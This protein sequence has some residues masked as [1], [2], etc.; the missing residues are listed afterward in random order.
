LVLGHS[1]V[2]LVWSLVI[3]KMNTPLLSFLGDDFTGSTDA[4]E[5]LS[6]AGLHTILFTNPPTRA[7]LDRHP[8]LQAFGIAS[9]TRA[10]NPHEMESTLPPIFAALKDSGAPIIHYKTCSTF[11]SSPKI[12]SIGKVIDIAMNQFNAKVIPTLVG[13]PSLGRHCV[14]GNLF[15]QSG[16]D[17]EPFRLD[18]HPSMSRH[19][20]TPMDEADL[21]LHLA[22]QTQKKIGLLDILALESSSPEKIFDHLV[23]TNHEIILIDMLYERQL[24]LAGALLDHLKDR[25]KPLFIVGSSG[26]E[27]ALAAHWNHPSKTFAPLTN[28]GPLIAV[29]GSCSP[30][31]AAQIQHAI[32]NGFDEIEINPLQIDEPATA[33]KASALIQQGKSV[34]LHTGMGNPAKRVSDLASQSI[35]PALGAILHR[36]LELS[37]LRRILIAGGDTSGQIA[38]ALSIE[39][40]EMIAPLTRGSPLCKIS[41][42]NS[43]A[44]NLEITFKGGQIGGK[45]FFTLVQNGK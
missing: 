11:D 6:R 35:G 27:S 9:T 38:R 42:P 10:M 39:S 44:H 43:P 18:R 23:D 17:S 24:P 7:Q 41:A 19:P 34:V 1:L 15:A 21:R 8:N 16:K 14:F 36:I 22:K 28:A 2:I 20:T 37:P 13:A 25:H 26:V 32:Q 4:M 40:L 5:S 29:C 45:D 12:G 31:T 30:V 3:F 33:A